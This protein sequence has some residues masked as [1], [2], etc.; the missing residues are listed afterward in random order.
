MSGVDGPELG[1]DM[2]VMEEDEEDNSYHWDRFSLF[3]SDESS[4]DE[5][6]DPV[7]SA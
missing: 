4:E 3:S 5:C 7:M 2:S 1:S 6:D